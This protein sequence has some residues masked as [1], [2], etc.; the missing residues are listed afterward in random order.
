MVSNVEN[1]VY[2]LESYLRWLTHHLVCVGTG[3]TVIP[4]ASG[5][6]GAFLRRAAPRAI[7]NKRHTKSRL[8][9][10][11]ST[12]LCLHSSWKNLPGLRRNSERSFNMFISMYLALMRRL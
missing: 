3:A 10:E 9:K 2:D 1:P 12:I 6:P 11:M 4:V 5:S 7:E 8:N